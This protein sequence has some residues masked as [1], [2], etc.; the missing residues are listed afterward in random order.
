[1]TIELKQEDVKP[2]VL[3]SD[4]EDELL[5][6][7]SLLLSL[8]TRVDMQ[9]SYATQ[10]FH[11]HD[12]KIKELK[13]LQAI[14]SDYAAEMSLLILCAKYLRLVFGFALQ[15]TFAAVL[16]LAVFATIVLFYPPVSPL[17][18]EFLM[19]NMVAY[20]TG[21]VDPFRLLLYYFGMFLMISVILA[22]L[23]YFRIL[24]YEFQGVKQYI[25]SI[26]PF[27]PIIKD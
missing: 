12:E 23:T 13:A 3:P 27:F 17:F 10:V 26:I 1:M 24:R 15:L 11:E 22:S 7:K 4:L 14:F 8:Q 18:H 5:H 2:E 16:F 19:L 6:I 20:G 9:H 25:I 21:D